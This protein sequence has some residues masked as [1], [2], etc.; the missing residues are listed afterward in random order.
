MTT[1]RTALTAE[2]ATI[3][4]VV[5]KGQG[6]AAYEITALAL[7]GNKYIG[8]AVSIRK[9]GSVTKQNNW[10]ELTALTTQEN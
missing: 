3:G 5:F 1:T 4:R 6:K 7:A 8:P 2:L 9:V 10:Q